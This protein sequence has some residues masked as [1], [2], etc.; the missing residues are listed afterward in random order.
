MGEIPEPVIIENPRYTNINKKMP[1]KKELKKQTE[2]PRPESELGYR[3]AGQAPRVAMDRGLER[4][5]LFQAIHDYVNEETGKQIYSTNGHCDWDMGIKKLV[6]RK[7][8]ILRKNKYVYP[9][10]LI[11]AEWGEA[12]LSDWRRGIWLLEVYGDEYLQ[13]MTEFARQLE[14]RFDVRVN[15]RLKQ[16]TP[17]KRKLHWSYD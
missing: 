12:N 3:N 2:T 11:L 17:L 15:V 8:G 1:E 9:G 13:E 10:E 4:N 6:E 7:K 5:D 14:R 16:H